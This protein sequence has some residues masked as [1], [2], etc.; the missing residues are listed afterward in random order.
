MRWHIKFFI[1]YPILFFLTRLE[2]TFSSKILIDIAPLLIDICLSIFSL[3]VVYKI[4][5]FIIRVLQLIP[6]VCR[7]ILKKFSFF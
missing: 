2:S 5:K 7:G 1:F 6:N 4:E 3:R